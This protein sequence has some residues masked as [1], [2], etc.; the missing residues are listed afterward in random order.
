MKRFRKITAFILVFVLF[1]NIAMPNFNGFVKADSS[2]DGYIDD[3]MALLKSVSQLNE[4]QGILTLSNGDAL[5]ILSNYDPAIY[6]NWTITISYTGG[7]LTV[8]ASANHNNVEYKF[9]GLG[10]EAHPFAGNWNIDAAVLPRSL[11]NYLSTDAKIKYDDSN[12]T[13][14]VKVYCLAPDQNGTRKYSTESIAVIAENLVVTGES[15]YIYNINSYNANYSVAYAALFGTIKGEA[16]NIIINSD[17]S[18]IGTDTDDV[19]VGRENAGLVCNTLMNGTLDLSGVTLP[20]EWTVKATSG[21]AGGLVGYAYGETGIICP[22]QIDNVKVNAFADND[23]YAGGLVGYM[24]EDVSLVL[25]GNIVMSV[26]L[27]SRYSSGGLAGFASNLVIEDEASP[28]TGVSIKASSIVATNGNA[29][30]LFGELVCTGQGTS[31]TSFDGR[32]NVNNSIINATGGSAGGLVGVLKYDEEAGTFEIGGSDQNY[33]SLGKD[34]TNT[35]SGNYA[36][37]V[38]GTYGQ[39][40]LK[41]TLKMAYIETDTL[42]GADTLYYGGAI[43][44]INSSFGNAY[45]EADSIITNMNRNGKA[46]NQCYGGF[47]AESQTGHFVNIGDFK[48]NAAGDGMGGITYGGVIGNIWSGVLRMHGN[49]DLTNAPASGTGEKIGQIVGTR[50]NALIYAMGSGTNEGWTL[51]R[52]K[53]VRVSDIGNYG[54]VLRHYGQLVLE[55]EGGLLTVDMVNH[56]VT[57]NTPATANTIASTNDFASMAMAVQLNSIKTGALNCMTQ[58]LWK[59]TIKLSADIDLS[60]TGLTG[61]WRDNGTAEDGASV[62]FQGTFDG[63]NHT[64]TFATGEAYGKRD[65]VPVTTETDG[66]GQLYRHA[67][68]GLF[69]VAKSATIRNLKAAGSIDFGADAAGHAGT[70][71]GSNL[72][73]TTTIENC[74]SDVDITYS[75]AEAYYVGGLIGTITGTTVGTSTIS[76]T[77]VSGSINHKTIGTTTATNSY[78]GGLIAYIQ[79]SVTGKPSN[80]VNLS[81]VSI[82]GLRIDTH[83]TTITGG[84]IGYEWQNSEVTFKN[85]FV[86]KDTD[87]NSALIN[88]GAANFG[89]LVYL[90]TGYWKVAKQDGKPGISINNADFVGN[91]NTADCTD[92]LL[93]YKGVF[94]KDNVN[95]ALYLEIGKDAYLIGDG[96]SIKETQTNRFDELVGIST[97]DVNAGANTQAIVSIATNDGLGVDLN[98][99][100]N[101]YT[102]KTTNDG[103]NWTPNPYSRYYY[104]LDKLR[105]NA[106]GT[107]AQTDNNIA[108]ANQLLCWSVSRYAAT[109][110][111]TYFGSDSSSVKLTGTTYDMR[112]LSYYPITVSKGGDLTFDG[113]NATIILDNE[114]IEK[115][116]LIKSSTVFS[117][118][119]ATVANNDTSKSQHY[120]MH[121]GLF[122][123]IN[124]TSDTNA[125]YTINVG[126]ITF[127]GNSGIDSLGKSGV[128]VSGTVSGMANSTNVYTQTLNAHDINFDDFYVVGTNKS[129]ALLVNKVVNNAGLIIN[130]IAG[131]YEAKEGMPDVAATSLIGDVGGTAASV[132]N[133]SLSFSSISLQDGHKPGKKPMFSNA[134]L[135]NSFVYPKNSGCT[136]VYNF[137]VE[138]D[139]TGSV[140]DHHNVTYGREIDVSTEYQ[141]REHWYYNTQDSVPKVTVNKTSNTKE[142]YSNEFS[143]DGYLPYV[144]N[145]GNVWVEEGTDHE[146]KVNVLVSDVINGCGTYGHPYEINSAAELQ[147]IADYIQSSATTPGNGWR[148][149]VT[150]Q[151]TLNGASAWHTDE[152]AAKCNIYI[153][154]DGKWVNEEDSEDILNND[155]MHE[156]LRNAYYMIVSDIT[157][158]KAFRGLGFQRT[159]AFRGVIT[160]KMKS[161][162]EYPTITINN[163]ALTA[164]DHAHGLINNSY[165]CVVKDLNIKLKSVDDTSVTVT[166]STKT[167]AVVNNYFG[168]VIGQ[169]L[170]GDN[171]IDNVSVDA[172]SAFMK[173]AGTYSY[174][175]PVGGYV[176]MHQGGGLLFRNNISKDMDLLVE[177]ATDYYYYVNPY[178]GRVLDAYAFY[179]KEGSS[180]PELNNTDKNYTIPTVD[181][182]KTGEDADVAVNLHDTSNG[183]YKDGTAF[184]LQA[185]VKSC[186]GLLVFSS[187]INSGASAGGFNSKGLYGSRAYYGKPGTYFG[188][189]NFGKVRNASYEYIGVDS[190]L[191]QED[192]SISKKDDL[193]I[194]TTEKYVTNKADRTGNA[195]YITNVPYIVE[196][197]TITDKDTDNYKN[198]AYEYSATSTRT[199]LTLEQNNYDMSI[200]GNGYRGIGGRYKSASVQTDDNEYNADRNSPFF[201]DILC[202]DSSYV[203]NMNVNEYFDDNFHVIGVGG[204]FNVLQQENNSKY[205]YLGGYPTYTLNNLFSG[206]TVSGN[207]KLEYHVGTTSTLNVSDTFYSAGVGGL[208][209]RTATRAQNEGKTT[210]NARDTRFFT[211][212]KNIKIKDLMVKGPHT[213]GGIIG[214]GGHTNYCVAGIRHSGNASNNVYAAHFTDCSIDGLT[215]EAAYHAGGLYGLSTSNVSSSSGTSSVNT[216]NVITNMTANNIT[217]KTDG[218]YSNSTAGVIAGRTDLGLIVNNIKVRNINI[219]AGIG[220]AGGLVGHSRQVARTTIIDGAS[221]GN[222]SDEMLK[223]SAL[224]SAGGAFGYNQQTLSVKDFGLYNSEINTLRAGGLAGYQ[225]NKPIDI[226]STIISNNK[227]TCQTCI[228]TN[229]DTNYAGGLVG[230]LDLAAG[231]TLT[232]DNILWEDNYQDEVNKFEYIT[233]LGKTSETHFYRIGTWVGRNCNNRTIQLVG[234]SRKISNPLAMIFPEETR[235]VNIKY[236]TIPSAYTGNGYIVYSDYTVDNSKKDPAADEDENLVNNVC[237]STSPDGIYTGGG[238]FVIDGLDLYGDAIANKAGGVTNVNTIF[239]ERKNTAP[240][241]GRVPYYSINVESFAFDKYMSL[242]SE[243]QVNSPEKTKFSEDFAVLL[244]SGNVNETINNYLNI[245]TNGGYN[246]AKASGIEGAVVASATTYKWNGSAFKKISVPSL[247]VKGL[248]Y[249]MSRAY[250]N[251]NDQFTLL[252]V[253]F[254]AGEHMHTVYVPVIVRRMV[255]IDFMATFAEGGVFE[256]SRFEGLKDHVLENFDTAITGYL[257]WKYNSSLGEYVE[258]DWQSYLEAG[259]NLTKSFN[260]S[261]VF[262][263]SGGY[264]PTGA[265]LALIDV[266]N[267][268]KTYFYTVAEDDVPKKDGEGMSIALDK[269]SDLSGNGYKQAPI[270]T[271]LNVTVTENETGLFV[272][273]NGAADATIVTKDGKYY[274]LAITDTTDDNY[275]ADQAKKHY[276]VS[277]NQTEAAK[278]D[279]YLVIM[280]PSSDAEAA[281]VIRVN[282]ALHTNVSLDVPSNITIIRRMNGTIDR[283]IDTESTFSIRSSYLQSLIDNSKDVTPKNLSTISKT[284]NIDVI[285]TVTF[286]IGQE[287]KD[288]DHL[289]HEFVITP[290]QVEGINGLRESTKY[291][292][293]DAATSANVNFYVYYKDS[294]G[295]YHY[296]TY[297]NGTLSDAGQTPTVCVTQGWNSSYGPMTLVLGD[298][299]NSVELSKIRQDIILNLQGV[300]VDGKDVTQGKFYIEAVA[301][302]EL[303]E[304]SFKE[305]IMVSGLDATNR[306]YNYTRFQYGAR[307]S[308]TNDFQTSIWRGNVQGSHSYYQNANGH[309]S[310][311]FD[312]DNI[313]QLGINLSDLPSKD[314]QVINAT[315]TFDVSKWTGVEDTLKRSDRVRFTMTFKQKQED[316]N[317]ITLN[318]AEDY[319][320]YMIVTESYK[321]GT[322]IQ[323]PLSYNNGCWIWDDINGSP[324]GISFANYSEG[325]SF[326]VPIEFAVKTDTN[327]S[328][329]NYANYR[330]EMKVEILAKSEDGGYSCQPILTGKENESVQSMS[331]YITY[332]FARVSTQFLNHSN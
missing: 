286:D 252:T 191:A 2:F 46:V 108:D 158:D 10:D 263:Y 309:A 80:K 20:K 111:K 41:S 114:T 117:T 276:I 226:S 120:L 163:T 13:N 272:E 284:I 241:G 290:H 123:N 84:L 189:Q 96:V 239:E 127:K 91:A 193:M 150:P 253:V 238:T 154:K 147:A 327:Q 38:I 211:D 70:L 234:V 9:R 259:A 23:G 251:D 99:T 97:T 27:S 48:H 105:L 145:K 69:S 210:E 207:V 195:F 231:N 303:S 299:S 329:F 281:D 71:I 246:K 301:D 255:E 11:F 172:D 212:F 171:I 160:G 3:D 271:I 94:T 125:N 269:F 289:Y 88:H 35:I 244:L 199:W 240:T 51:E 320:Q 236:N 36:G 122:Y 256:A 121:F 165:G 34:G 294:K 119:S 296:Y 118:R 162:G 12:N 152:A 242:Y 135:L 62:G 129:G 102:N 159:Y 254:T 113:N 148:V 222:L 214:A 126:K 5:V 52:S 229:N 85:V 56:R 277:I 310:F 330:I 237:V 185:N 170:G 83:A 116:E 40:S 137:N 95:Y 164:S 267:R 304:V 87:N 178:I 317:Y 104:N 151:E 68:I 257:T 206:L 283:Q 106:G 25:A 245:I 180:A 173:L 179:E 321:D 136:A 326:S 134:M 157:L 39:K 53:S 30:G 184:L 74:Q 153:V 8:P 31:I 232:G 124:E 323:K 230:Y 16:G 249:S 57:V 75:G 98:G 266:A 6:E 177:N 15:G 174:L 141:D 225:N 204:L 258:Y 115:A 319:I 59:S 305:L 332:T 26:D 156:Y 54:Q 78:L 4:E 216:S 89:G 130:N 247:T 235:T 318:N 182:T 64:I 175:V 140:W 142:T 220:Y 197:Y 186:Q 201:V 22:D 302:V 228:K 307:L 47:V 167:E 14:N 196:H 308:R 316:G 282:G 215:V 138:D 43:G 280:V 328:N 181:S 265:Q 217:L 192:Y 19:L 202:N 209:G 322:V 73:G 50:G 324:S 44:A 295:K 24:G 139:F 314:P 198:L 219:D 100:P 112:G 42:L 132:K 278:E 200:Y 300:K 29:G 86:D 293:D 58:D 72:N 224:Y 313:N 155:Y 287:Y 65:G 279:F 275:A 63:Q 260:K 67:Y 208:I 128:L 250:D 77:S 243:Q 76:G 188:N 325:E 312:A 45:V 218:I 262:E 18:S 203:L 248:N 183:I 168:G 264:M 66:S 21:S 82:E 311:S 213:A 315:A 221:V 297:A 133:I 176:G 270:G 268:D 306:P 144:Y 90:A 292:L 101:T 274:R 166:E 131:S 187:M 28:F 146:I 109:N 261:L 190:A 1:M 169:I 143:T 194:A 288:T 49:T 161:D 285:D 291:F 93:V 110:I 331:D 273:A 60:G 17:L 149:R 81:D 7:I 33:M 227:F 103:A 233:N 55:G 107:V 32:F 79:A 205:A 37:G 298:G 61:L 92:G 223:I